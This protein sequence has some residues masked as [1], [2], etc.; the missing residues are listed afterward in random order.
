[1]LIWIGNL[2]EEI[3]YYLKRTRGGWGWYAA[4]A[5]VFHFPIPFL[6]LL[7][8]HVKSSP[9]ALRNICVMLIAVVFID[10]MWWI[11][12]TISHAEAPKFYWLMDVAAWVGVGGLW[13]F[14]FLG[15]LK[16]HPLL[17]TRE[18]YLLEAYHHGH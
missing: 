10:V 16:K 7:F 6:L 1:M 18:V 14:V 12:P 11:S 4:L 2:P 3:P 13:I 5:V 9:V 15:Q 17:P 8:R